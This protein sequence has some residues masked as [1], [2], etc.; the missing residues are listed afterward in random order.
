M[1]FNQLSIARRLW[2][3]VGLL[4]VALVSI[5]LF[6]G[7]RSASTQKVAE[8]QMAQAAERL[9]TV[10]EWARLSE[11]TIARATAA[12]LSKD[13]AVGAHFK[14]M[15]DQ[16]VEHIN[17]LKKQIE[18]MDLTT[19]DRDQIRLIGEARAKVLG[20]HKKVSE[21]KT[22]GDEA[23]AQK[24]FNEVFVP[25]VDVYTKALYA[26]AAMQEEQGVALRAHIADA[27]R[28]TVAMAAGMIVVVL[29]G[30][31]L[32]AHVLIRSI[33]L[34]LAHAAEVTQRIAE[35]DLTVQVRVD[36]EDEVGQMLLALQGM[37]ASLVNLVGDIRHSTDSIATASSEIASGNQDLSSRTE[38]TASNLEQTASSME[39]LTGTVRQTA[40]SAR[41]ANQLATSA[42]D[43]AQ[44][45]G[46]V[47]AQ[48]VAN[49]EGIAHA[50][51]KIA[52]IIG[53][54]DGIAFQT[55]ILALNAAVEAA[56]AGEQ[57]RG[58]A[59]V[60]SEVRSLAQRSAEA[61]KEIKSLIVDSTEKVDAGA[62]LVS[63]AGVTMQDIVTAIQRVT[64]TMAEISTSAAEQSDGISQVNQAV[65]QLDNMTQQ[66]AA[67]VEESAAAAASL[68]Q[69]ADHLT[70]VVSVFR[71]NTDR[72][73]RQDPKLP[74]LP[75]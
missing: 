6:A 69:Q 8:V 26:F 57:G 56:R 2:V 30:V 72:T 62:R 43:A 66:N 19:A 7:W 21:F 34:P 28:T 68:R 15:N 29:I 5:V 61:A 16:I 46:E 50:S 36:R 33:K 75:A 48:V 49:M 25:A 63:D 53:V 18:A 55:N 20:S 4:I 39:E 17:G 54:I 65:T 59:V 11:L 35:G 42:S 64:D 22:A 31:V 10:Q 23:G 73:A 41:V 13:P 3:A 27:R 40:D 67:L 47:V 51:R 74:L 38:Q 52:D 1:R 32:G 12:V 44:R 9:K 70:Q 14:P 37:A 45:G 24:E 60:A 58:F 71:L